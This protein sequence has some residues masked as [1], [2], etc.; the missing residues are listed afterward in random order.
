[1]DVDQADLIEEGVDGD[2]E[3]SQDE[4]GQVEDEDEDDDEGDEDQMDLDKDPV[5]VYGDKEFNMLAP[6]STSLPQPTNTTTINPAALTPSQAL[7]ITDPIGFQ[8]CGHDVKH[9][10]V[11]ARAFL[12]LDATIVRDLLVDLLYTQYKCIVPRTT[13]TEEQF[14]ILVLSSASA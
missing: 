8:A 5:S 11:F 6:A 9:S 3:D 10:A 2:G 13:L 12:I 7:T 4:D 14:F 1:M